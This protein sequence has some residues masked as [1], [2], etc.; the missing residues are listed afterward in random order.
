MKNRKKL[1]QFHLVTIIVAV[2]QG[3][4]GT[5]FKAQTNSFCEY[6]FM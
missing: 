2:A 6:S 1:S 5:P 4:F 3:T